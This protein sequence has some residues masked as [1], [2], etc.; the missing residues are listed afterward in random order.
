MLSACYLIAVYFRHITWTGRTN[1][2]TSPIASFDVALPSGRASH[3]SRRISV[4]NGAVFIDLSLLNLNHLL[5]DREIYWPEPEFRWNSKRNARGEERIK[6]I[7]VE[8]NAEYVIMVFAFDSS[9]TNVWRPCQHSGNQS[10]NIF[11]FP[12]PT[13]SEGE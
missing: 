8:R 10:K 1:A 6:W 5:F 11:T 12:M 7:Y 2:A 13:L 9:L 3:R 4:A